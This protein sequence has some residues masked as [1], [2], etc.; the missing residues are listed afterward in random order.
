MANGSQSGSN[1]WSW[2]LGGCL[3]AIVALGLVVCGAGFMLVQWGKGVERELKDPATRT[4]KAKRVL[5]ATE[6]PEGY[7]AMVALSIPYIAD[8]AVLTDKAPDDKGNIP[9]FGARGLIYMRSMRLGGNPQEIEDFV[10]GKTDDVDALRRN[11]INIGPGDVLARGTLEGRA[12]AESLLYLV[13]RG[14]LQMNEHS[15]QGLSALVMPKCAPAD[16]KQ[17]IAIWFCPEPE[18]AK[19]LKPDAAD[20]AASAAAVGAALAGSCGDPQEIAAFM[21]HFRPCGGP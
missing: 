15:V 18:A 19:G 6:L 12:G 20:P 10:T 17:R 11:K 4:E 5:G 3:V 2:F 7:Y 21:D 13:K 16:G 14:S 1:S 8:I 9:G